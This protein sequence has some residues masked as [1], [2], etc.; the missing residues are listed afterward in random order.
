MNHNH[1]HDGKR[2]AL[3]REATLARSRLL[4]KVEELE[5]RGHEAL[6]LR[7]Q[8]RSHVRQVVAAGVLLT[9]AAVGAVALLVHRLTAAAER[10]RLGRGGVLHGGWRAPSH[11][12]PPPEQRGFLAEAL[13]SFLIGAITTT[14]MIPIRRFASELHGN[15]RTPW[16]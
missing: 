16:R 15:A 9:A 13:R 8:L 1:N 12:A 11:P 5:R 6:D 3:E 7:V 10:R 2:V 14:A 4:H